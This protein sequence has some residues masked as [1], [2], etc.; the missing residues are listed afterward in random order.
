MEACAELN[1]AHSD[2]LCFF[3]PY[4]RG[5]VTA[6][7]GPVDTVVVVHQRGQPL[8]R[9]PTR[10][11]FELAES[12]YYTHSEAACPALQKRVREEVLRRVFASK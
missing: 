4:A 12:M 9:M 1:E 10:K 5:A 8:S 6:V 3:L 11:L 7:R 2:G